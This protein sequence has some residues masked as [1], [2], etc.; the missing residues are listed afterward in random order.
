MASLVPCPSCTRHVRIGE[1]SC[2]FCSAAVPSDLRPRIALSSPGA[3]LSRA[4]IFA[5]GTSAATLACGGIEGVP[6]GSS[7]SSGSSSSSG[8]S[9]HG[10]S[11]G[12]SSGYGS[13]GSSSGYGSSGSAVPPYGGPPPIDAGSEPD[14][15]GTGTDAI[16]PPYGLPPPD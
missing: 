6:T 12:S 13:S 11:S 1:S 15:A 8:S 4:A 9:G 2:P 10:G 7:G 5:L 3:R 16:A 14:D